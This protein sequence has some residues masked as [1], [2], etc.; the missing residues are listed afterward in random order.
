MIE[1]LYEQFPIMKKLKEERV[2]SV[3]EDGEGEI[4]IMERCDEWFSAVITKE[5]AKEISD[6]FLLLSKQMQRS[7][8]NFKPF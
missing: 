7:E 1:K 6:F 3:E 4:E 5:D 8:I 2:F